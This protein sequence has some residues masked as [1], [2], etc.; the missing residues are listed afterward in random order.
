MVRYHPR[1]L[2]IAASK[3]VAMAW[4]CDTFGWPEHPQPDPSAPQLLVGNS[5]SCKRESP[6]ACRV[7]TTSL[8]AVF[9]E[10]YEVPPSMGPTAQKMNAP[11]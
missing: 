2:R 8:I 11:G 1:V 4:C 5:T 7:E 9:A 6:A 10:A 3:M